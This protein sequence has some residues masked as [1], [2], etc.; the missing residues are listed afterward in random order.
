MAA[1]LAVLAAPL[2][3]ADRTTLLGQSAPDFALR[4]VAGPNVRLSEQRGEV[5]VVAF[6]SSRCSACRAHLQELDALHGSL[7]SLG[8]IVY[9]VNVDDNVKAAREFAASV[10]VG[11]PMLLDPRKDVA[12]AY[13][14]DAL[15]MMVTIDRQGLVRS[16]RRDDRGGAPGLA[17]AELRRLLAQ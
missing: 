7:K 2:S 17:G 9:A 12:R 3:A 16:I 8:L 6:W 4:Q 5:I 1:L 14:V 13:R 11:F 15:P 10:P